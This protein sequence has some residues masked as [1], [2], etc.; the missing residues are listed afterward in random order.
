MVTDASGSTIASA[1]W[2]EATD[3]EAP[4]L[5]IAPHG[6][7]AGPAARAMLHPKVNDLHT[8]DITRELALRLR[9][10]AII[11]VRMDRNRLD[12]NRL[13]QVMGTV[14]WVLEM[15]VERLEHIIARHQRAVVLLI[16]GWNV[17][18]PRVDVGVG[19]RSAGGA[20]RP[21]RGA[22]LSASSG[23]INGALF[24][25]A[26]RLRHGGIIAS[27]GL[28]YPGGGADN[29][30]QAF[31]QRHAHSHSD[32]LR[33]LASLSARGTL[34]AVQLELSVALRMPGRLRA[35]TID[36]ITQSFT[37]PGRSSAY[38][39]NGTAILNA[40][41]LAAPTAT[42]LRAS[43]ASPAS[44][45]RVGLEFYDPSARIGVLASF[46][47]GAGAAGARVMVLLERERI[48]LFTAE[49][50]VER[51]SRSLVLGAL[52]LASEDGGLA[53][54]FRG[55]VFVVEDGRSYLS[56]ESALSKGTLHECME[57]RARFVRWPSTSAAAEK[58][59]TVLDRI[60][61]PDPGAEA[62]FGRAAGSLA[63]MGMQRDLQAVARAGRSFTGI[64]P[65]TFRTRR[66]M[67]AAF[68]DGI[69]P[70][71][72]EARAVAR[73]DGVHRAA[74]RMLSDGRWIDVI[75]RSVTL[76]PLAAA[77]PPERIF[78]VLEHGD[79]AQLAVSG[80][81][82]SFA[83]LSRPGPA[84]SRIITSLGF[85]HF[86]LGDHMGAGMFEYSERSAEAPEAVSAPD[87]GE[88]D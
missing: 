42:V 59:S 18:E 68:V 19:L 34:E 57:L 1:E 25:F 7:Q 82:R 49:G 37:P 63:L 75:A 83:M 51:D 60:L 4:L 56:V 29:L 15:I 48:A 71:A 65:G 85:A 10:P 78:A 2:L 6:G 5:L 33:R 55:P 11:N 87:D 86:R 45:V 64:G 21:A 88:S 8:S 66:M 32:A 22:H 67:W 30:L 24:D 69:A 17:I 23:F 73:D 28:R 54:D 46:D 9:A 70:R 47:V 3:G 35:E 62:V 61:D 72:V 43:D 79:G 38:T 41:P 40:D 50:R 39:G 81:M 84:R 77:E 52:R 76:E 31:T 80:A 74:A 14:P 36:A 44:P 20:V 13:S 27:F 53:F 26:E 12:L 16:H 58:S